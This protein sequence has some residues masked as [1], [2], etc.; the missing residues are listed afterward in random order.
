MSLF[1]YPV[2][3]VHLV[4][5]SQE[6]EEIELRINAASI[7]PGELYPSSPYSDDTDVKR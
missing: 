4:T 6:C 7:K 1:E 2:G 3:E 5:L